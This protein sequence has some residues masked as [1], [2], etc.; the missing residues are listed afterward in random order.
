MYLNS[1][2]ADYPGETRVIPQNST[3]RLWVTITFYPNGWGTFFLYYGM[4][5]QSFVYLGG[6]PTD[7]LG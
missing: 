5:W 3:I 1:T 7:Q 2:E 4:T 6:V